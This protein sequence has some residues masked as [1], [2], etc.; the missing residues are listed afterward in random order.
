MRLLCWWATGALLFI[1]SIAYAAEVD[2]CLDA[3]KAGQELRDQT[4]LVE[5]KSRF[6]RCAQATCPSAVARDCI[7]W[8][9]EVE[10]RIPR[11]ALRVRMDGRDVTSARASIDGSSVPM[12]GRGA[13]L[14]PGNHS[15]RVILEDGTELQ[16]DV[17][18]R[19]GELNRIET[20]E[21]KLPVRTAPT[22]TESSPPYLAYGFFGAAGVSLLVSGVAGY[23]GYQRYNDLSES[24]RPGWCTQADVASTNRAFVVADIGLIAALTFA[25]SGGIVYALSGR[26]SRAGR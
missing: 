23:W 22:Q 4:K 6:Q 7:Q 21:R 5:A 16:R 12:F 25:V 8:L 19:E 9:S 2:I 18:L 15:V 13:E 11:L 24:C 1:P 3:A 26:S 14:N 17:V 10:T 20:F